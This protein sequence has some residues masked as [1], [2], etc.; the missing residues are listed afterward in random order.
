[1][2]SLGEPTGPAT[3]DELAD[4]LELAHAQRTPFIPRLRTWAQQSVGDFWSPRLVNLRRLEIV[5][6]KDQEHCIPFP[7]EFDRPKTLAR[8][9]LV[10]DAARFDLNPTSIRSLASNSVITGLTHISQSDSKQSRRFKLRHLTSDTERTASQLIVPLRQRFGGGDEFREVLLTYGFRIHEGLS[11][12][13]VSMFRGPA[14]A[15]S[16]P[17]G[18]RLAL[19]SA[20]VC[21]SR[22]SS[23]RGVNRAPNSRSTSSRRFRRSRAKRA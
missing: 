18:R 12:K 9:R 13:G 5:V 4:R 8:F 19:V 21:R 7:V 16:Y 1:M 22:R 3:P 20:E 10:E 6:E 2:L 15:S 23:S 14:A 17:N 11:F